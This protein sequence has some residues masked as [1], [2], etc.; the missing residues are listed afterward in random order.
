EVLHPPLEVNARQLEAGRAR[1]G[2]IGV[3]ISELFYISEA[4]GLIEL[5]PLRR[6]GSA[7]RAEVHPDDDPDSYRGD[8]SAS[9]EP[10]LL[11]GMDLEAVAKAVHQSAQA[12]GQRVR[13][14]F[15]AMFRLHAGVPL[16][17]NR[18][19]SCRYVQSISMQ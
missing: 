13:L 17:A 2:A 16:A 8:D 15:L 18:D 12:V 3:F 6:L 14:K 5:D 11:G 9:D 19:W 4:A 10:R 7:N 1:R